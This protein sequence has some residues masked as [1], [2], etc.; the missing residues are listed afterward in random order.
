[1]SDLHPILAAFC[2]HNPVLAAWCLPAT[3]LIKFAS[4][5][6]GALALS[7]DAAEATGEHCLLNFEAGGDDVVLGPSQCAL[8]V[9][10]QLRGTRGVTSRGASG[11]GSEAATAHA[12]VAATADTRTGT[13]APS[14]PTPTV[15]AEYDAYVHGDGAHVVVSEGALLGEVTLLAPYVVDRTEKRCSA[16]DVTALTS[17]YAASPPPTATTSSSSSSSASSSTSSTSSTSSSSPFSASTTTQSPH[18]LS[19]HTLVSSLDPPTRFTP[20]T[21]GMLIILDNTRLSRFLRAR[22]ALGGVLAHAWSEAAAAHL[23][24]LGATAHA[25]LERRLTAE[26]AEARENA[27]QSAKTAG[28]ALAEAAALRSLMVDTRATAEARGAALTALEGELRGQVAEAEKERTSWSR[29]ALLHTETIRLVSEEA[30]RVRHSLSELRRAYMVLSS[31]A[32]GGEQAV[33]SARAEQVRRVMA[34]CVRRVYGSSSICDID[35]SGKGELCCYP[36]CVC[37]VSAY[38]WAWIGGGGW[39]MRRTDRVVCCLTVD[40]FG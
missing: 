10:G 30:A 27:R 18:P 29:R 2:A 26:A 33:E 12:A 14:P 38:V 24:T 34:Q 13:G 39:R 32:A 37:G 23:R 36:M 20:L 28:A 15:A 7:Q 8:V 16:D 40:L 9:R 1:M 3:E 19:D 17:T 31:A 6:D 22:P 5:I 21:S 11:A 4:F 35:T 25:V